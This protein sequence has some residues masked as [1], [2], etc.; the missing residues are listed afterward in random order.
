[1][2]FDGWVEAAIYERAKL[3]AGDVIDGPAV[4][5]EFS[6]TIPVHPG[7]RAE[8]D[9]FGNVRMTRTAHESDTA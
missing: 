6:S 1:M 2:C 7:F 3:G 9:E 4:L 8:V 5:E